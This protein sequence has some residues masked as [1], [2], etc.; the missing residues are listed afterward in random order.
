M[1]TL[2]SLIE[3]IQQFSNPVI[4]EAWASELSGIQNGKLKFVNTL[5]PPN[6]L[7]KPRNGT[8]QLKKIIFKNGNLNISSNKFLSD[9]KLL[10]AKLSIS[11]HKRWV[12]CYQNSYLFTVALFAVLCSNRHP[13][14][15]PNNQHGTIRFFAHEF[16]AVLSDNTQL[17]E[18]SDQSNFFQSILSEDQTLTLFTSGSTGTPKKISRTLKQL[19]NEIEI[20]ELLFHSQI[21]HSLIYS[22]VSHQHIYGLLFY[23]LWPMCAGRTICFSALNYPKS[24]ESAIQ[25]TPSVTLI[26]SPA[27]LAR[28]NNKKIT[29][30]QLTIFSSGGLLKKQDA[31]KVYQSTG[32]FP[33][34]VLGSTETSGVGFRQQNDSAADSSWIPLPKVKIQIDSNTQC[35]K[36]QSPFFEGK[37]GFVMGDKVKINQDGTF[38]LLERADR[39]AKIEEKRVSLVE[40]EEKLKQYALINDAYA[41]PM[42][43]NRQYI[44][45]VIVLRQEGKDI[46]NEKG[47]IFLN[48]ELKNLMSQY[49]D[50]I[51]LPKRFRYIDEIP[52]NQQGKYVISDIR[53][54]FE[55]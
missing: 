48:E 2:F 30:K 45:V 25:S 52:V 15:L 17:T 46:L 47:K 36:V 7:I 33:I 53:K 26:S 42:E 39:I 27:L 12:L 44:A 24:I 13:V 55:N 5:E 14:L 3:T 9:V 18:H 20:L 51:L 4:P 32:T 43:S 37:N 35:L 16:D 1:Q 19:M 6:S 21:E 54:L 29:V 50:R 41:I 28:M 38:Q 23:I 34:E 11:Q 31:L 22:T 10:A 49:F 8:D 40:I